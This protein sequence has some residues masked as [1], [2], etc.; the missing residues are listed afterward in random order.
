MGIIFS[1]CLKNHEDNDDHHQENDALLY[2]NNDG[3]NGYDSMKRELEIEEQKMLARENELTDI[4]NNT[5]DKLI[6]ISVMNN[7]GTNN[8]GN[9]NLHDDVDTTNSNHAT[10]SVTAISSP[11]GFVKVNHKFNILDTNSSLTSLEKEKLKKLW[12]V[13]INGYIGQ[14]TIDFD[15]PLVASL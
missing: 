6:D 10:S 3:N 13:I 12:D 5:N 14:F 9:N 2:N 11:S 15:E 4:V 1:C 8:N 7:N